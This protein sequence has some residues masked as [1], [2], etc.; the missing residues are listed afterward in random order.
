MDRG[1]RTWTWPELEIEPEAA[2]GLIR[3]GVRVFPEI[4]IPFVGDVAEFRH[5]SAVVDKVARDVERETG[6]Q[7]PCLVGTMIEIP[8]AALTANEIASE[9][10]RLRA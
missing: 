10:G 2:A 3:G 5:Q 1:Y 4:M 9:N 6:T 8:R 7:V